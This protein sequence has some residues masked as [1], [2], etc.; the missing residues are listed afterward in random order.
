MYDTYDEDY[1]PVERLNRS[2]QKREINALRDLAVSLSKLDIPPLERLQLPAELFKAIVAVQSMKHAAAKRQ[3]KFIVKLLREND[4]ESLLETIDGLETKKAD[5][6]QNFHRIER[7]RDRLVN[8]GPETI[9]EFISAYPHANASQIRQ[10]IRNASRELATHKP[11]KSHRALFRLL[12]E[13]I[14]ITN[15][16]TESDTELESAPYDDASDLEK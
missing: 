2:Q 1:Q 15:T 11:P 10:L 14:I 9:T 16:E 3:F 6:D 13:E 7:W 4:T 8:E 12:R 5:Q